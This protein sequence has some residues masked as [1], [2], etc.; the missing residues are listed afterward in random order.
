MLSAINLSTLCG[1]LSLSLLDAVLTL[2]GMWNA[3]RNER[4]KKA[5]KVRPQSNELHTFTVNYRYVRIDREWPY[6]FVPRDGN[7]S[8]PLN[9]NWV[10]WSV[11][12]FDTICV[13]LL[14]KVVQIITYSHSLWF[15]KS[16]CNEKSWSWW[17]ASRNKQKK[18]TIDQTG[19]KAR[20]KKSHKRINGL[21]ETKK[22]WNDRQ[23][24]KCTKLKTK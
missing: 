3:L 24:K 2:N 5:A 7:V 23:G 15:G 8:I 9:F 13:R 1:F 17:D 6:L 4:A 16:E 10:S 21:A 11:W 20:I 19:I 12:S 22:A 18:T 14:S